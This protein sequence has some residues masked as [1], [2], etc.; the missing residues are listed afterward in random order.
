MSMDAPKELFPPKFIGDEPKLT[1][2]KPVLS[3]EPLLVGDLRKVNW[4]YMS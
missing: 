4:L 3:N 1:E 2:V